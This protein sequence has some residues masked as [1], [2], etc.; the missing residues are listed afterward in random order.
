MSE[1]MKMDRSKSLQELEG[2]DWG[3]P[4][5]AETPMIGRVLA[6]R[7]KPLERLSNGEVRLAVGQRVGFPLILA[8][9]LDR[10]RADPLIEADYYPGDV[11]AALVRLDEKDWAGKDDLRARLAELF[12]RAMESSSEDADAFRASLELPSSGSTA[13]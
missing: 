3:D 10:L 7:R 11:L 13:N 5:S 2:V 9:A 4:G 1:I 8:L 6:L 12:T